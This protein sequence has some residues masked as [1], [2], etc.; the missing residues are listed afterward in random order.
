MSILIFILI[1]VA[2]I[3]VHEFGHFV[4]AKLAKIKVEEFGIF[5]PPKLFGIKKGETLYTLNA[6][7]F[8]GFVRIFGENHNEHAGDPR[9][10]ASKPRYTQALVVVAGVVM[11]IIFAWWAL[12]AAYMVGLP[13]SAHHEGLGQVQNPEVMIVGVLPDSPA[14]R[15]GILPED[16][17]K[18]V[19]SATAKL[20]VE[21]LSTN[22]QAQ[23]VQNFI[24]E[25]SEQSLVLTVVRAG[26][27]DVFLAKA[28]EGIVE[29]RK[30][31]G[32]Q[33]DDI[34]TLQLPAH[35]ALV[36]GAR[37]TYTMTTLTAQGLGT[38]FAQ[39]ARG[40][41]DFNSVAGPIGIVNL[42]AGAV[43]GGFAAAAVLTALIS[44]NLA[45]LN[46]LPIPGL[47]GGRLVIIGVEGVLRRPV[48]R[49]LTVA[50]TV[51]GFALLITLMIA[52]SVNDIARLVG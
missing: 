34:G 41:A 21:T 15:A 35:L 4:V 19:E 28:E 38:F 24:G 12:S 48:S 40:L 8:G 13:T 26:E 6:L 52:V 49:K 39:I 43:E 47:D 44:V 7:P 10:F 9:S 36:E 46:L 32:V 22:E 51:A 18:V 2:L 37:L 33:L 29:G 16:V 11:N 31:L 30:A 14:A 3:L 27:E 20:E 17:I 25:H 1:L 45:I 5:F 42:G 23:A 50:L